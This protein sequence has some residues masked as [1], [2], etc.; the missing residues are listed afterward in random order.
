[1]KQTKPYISE[2]KDNETIKRVF[3][4]AAKDVKKDKNNRPY[5]DLKLADKTGSI[6]AKMWNNANIDRLDKSFAKD[7]FIYVAGK[8]EASAKYG[9]QI[10]VD[11]LDRIEETD[12]DLSDFVRQSG[13]DVELL[14][15]QLSEAME[16]IENPHLSKLGTL[17]FKDKEFIDSFK[18]A[19]ASITHHQGY[20]GGLL[21]HTVAILSLAKNLLVSYPKLNRD[22][23]LFGV[24]LHDIGK[25]KEYQI[26]LRPDHT[27]EGRLIGHTVLGILML[28]ERAKAIKDFPVE[29]L[30]QLR[31][32]IISHHGEREYG[33]PVVPMTAEAMAL[34]F[35]DNI[36][37]RL[38]EYYEITETLPAEAVWTNWL[39]SLDRR[40]Y[41]PPETV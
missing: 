12:I 9:R 33:A 23:L 30:M 36:D 16:A 18:K 24:F 11:S 20:L 27:D 1:M 17:F 6:P 26:K 28:E 7:D 31:H 34:H 35:L 21:E 19:P 25:V 4:V 13:Q 3:L 40:F 41:R 22:L 15:S 14:F 29:L 5:F 37:A 38:A 8:L 2:L 32:L 10:I 39:P